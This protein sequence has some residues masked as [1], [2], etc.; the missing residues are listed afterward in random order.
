MS[1]IDVGIRELKA[2]L[3]EYVATAARGESI[4]VTDRG[5]P[6][7]Q[8]TGLDAHSAI[9]RGIDEGWIEAPLRRGLA[10]IARFKS[11]T[12]TAAALDDDRG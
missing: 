9:E 10:P 2:K 6:V 12:S 11:A 5:K 4:T 1:Q 8:L 3:S 7:A